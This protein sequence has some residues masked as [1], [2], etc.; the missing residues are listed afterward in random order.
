MT[1]VVTTLQRKLKTQ[2][3]NSDIQNETLHKNDIKKQNTKDHE[4]ISKYGSEP[5]KMGKKSTLSKQYQ[6]TCIRKIIETKL[7]HPNKHKRQR[8]SKGNQN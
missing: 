5:N 6:N 1:G 7:I 2:Q 4:L 3:H 8:T